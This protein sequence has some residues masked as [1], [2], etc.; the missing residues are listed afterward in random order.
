MERVF[1]KINCNTTLEFRRLNADH[2]R[3]VTMRGMVLGQVWN[4]CAWLA[5]RPQGYISPYMVE[6]ILDVATLLPS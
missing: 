2:W 3:V 4:G 1:I 6:A 5:D